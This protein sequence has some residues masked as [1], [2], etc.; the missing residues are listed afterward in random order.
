[1]GCGTDTVQLL[2]LRLPVPA[3]DTAQGFVGR[4]FAQDALHCGQERIQT[5]FSDSTTSKP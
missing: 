2:K 3:A 4:G 1:M 5:P